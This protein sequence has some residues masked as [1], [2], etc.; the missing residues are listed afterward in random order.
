MLVF[1][2]KLT[3]QTI[4]T[5]GLLKLRFL[6]LNLPCLLVCSNLSICPWAQEPGK[7]CDI[8]SA[9]TWT[10]LFQLGSAAGLFPLTPGSAVSSSH[11]LLPLVPGCIGQKWAEL[12]LQR[13]DM[14]NAPLGVNCCGQLSLE[15]E[16]EGREDGVWLG[17]LLA[18]IYAPVAVLGRLGW[19]RFILKMTGWSNGFMLLCSSH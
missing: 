16:A 19:S 12:T 4:S 10:S 2:A 18:A 3:G 7:Q 8:G 15:A 9:G 14:V 17:S 5:L 11:S 13:V 6:S 1:P